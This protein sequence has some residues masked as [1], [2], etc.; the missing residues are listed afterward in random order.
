MYITDTQTHTQ[1]HTYT[2]THI[3]TH[4]TRRTFVFFAAGAAANCAFNDNCAFNAAP[5]AFA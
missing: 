3:H 1:T 5:C 2:H 4:T